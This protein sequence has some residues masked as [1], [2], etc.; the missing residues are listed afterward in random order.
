MERAEATGARYAGFASTD[1]FF[2]RRRKW[3][4][5]ALITGDMFLLRRMPGIE[6]PMMHIEDYWLSLRELAQVG[7]V[8]VNRYARAETTHYDP[9]GYGTREGPRRKLRDNEV[10]LML[11]RY[12]G[13]VR[14]KERAG[15]YPDIALRSYSRKALDAWRA[16][17]A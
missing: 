17:R 9:A 16:A 4:D 13:L 1:N 7:R 14:V 11:H 8:V 3:G 10:R 5:I 12:E 15:G 2:F 6:F